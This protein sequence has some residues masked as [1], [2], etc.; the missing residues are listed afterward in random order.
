MYKF[1][2][3][4]GGVRGADSRIDFLCSSNGKSLRNPR[5]KLTPTITK[6]TDKN[7]SL[8]INLQ[9]TKKRRNSCVIAACREA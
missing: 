9:H 7:R 4:F 6:N 1:Y 3:G 8:S 2:S 5:Q